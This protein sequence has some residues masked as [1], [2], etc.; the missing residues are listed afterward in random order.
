VDVSFPWDPLHYP[1]EVPPYSF[2]WSVGR[3]E[4]VAPTGAVDAHSWGRHPVLA[5]GSNASPGQLTRKFGAGQFADP[6]SPDGVIPVLTAVARGVDVVYGAHL[7]PY[8]SLPA[9]LLDTP[10]ASARV[11]VTWLTPRQRRRMDETEDLGH[12][13]QL[14][15]MSDVHCHGEKLDSALSYVTT[16]GAC[17]LGGTPLGLA[18][19]D[20]PGSPRPR[21]TQ[22]QAWNRLSQDMG[23]DGDGPALLQNVLASPA[24]RERV[25]SHLAVN[26]LEE[27]HTPVAS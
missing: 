6:A 3:V 12:S 21:A 16:A 20:A 1:F 5:I 18:A 22:R 8:G 24:W 23:G 10:G 7:A 14:R 4:P 17:V 11:F 27:A 15:S 9:T 13:Y 25:E 19:V 26:R 2:V